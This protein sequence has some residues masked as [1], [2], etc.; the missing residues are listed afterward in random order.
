MMKGMKPR[1]TATIIL[2]IG[3]LAFVGIFLI[4][5]TGSMSIL[6][7]IGVIIVSMVVLAG[8]LAA[9]WAS[10]G[11]GVAFKQKELCDCIGECTC[12][13]KPK[14]SKRAKRPKRK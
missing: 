10:W 3:W 2:G 4:F 1:V 13:E 12:M 8:L 11:M 6:Q 7:V 14:K 9:M 5:W